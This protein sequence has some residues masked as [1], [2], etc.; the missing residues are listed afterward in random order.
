MTDN[1]LPFESLEEVCKSWS[2]AVRKLVGSD[3]YLT[4]NEDKLEMLL[5]DIPY[6]GH[7]VKSILLNKCQGGV[8]IPDQLSKTLLHCPNLTLI[9]FSGTGTYTR[10]KMLTQRETQLKTLQKIITDHNEVISL[11]TD[12]WG[13]LDNDSIIDLTGFKYDDSH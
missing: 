12:N 6:F 1:G 11:T 3:I 4:I 8:E 2:L 7:E 10:L 13:N 5:K 9:A